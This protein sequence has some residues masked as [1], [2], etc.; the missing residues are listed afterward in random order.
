MTASPNN[1]FQ[2]SSM[3]TGVALCFVLRISIDRSVWLDPSLN[4][5][6]WVEEFFRFSRRGISM[7]FRV[8]GRVNK[9]GKE[10][11]SEGIRDQSKQVR[12][13]KT[14]LVSMTSH[15]NISVRIA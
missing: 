4:I 13:G 11:P 6:S 2:F 10:R 7:L 1:S 5:R 15:A 3:K 12:S 9:M 8:K 14:H